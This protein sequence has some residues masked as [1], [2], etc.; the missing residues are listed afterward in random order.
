MQLRQQR[1]YI[2]NRTD[3]DSSRNALIQFDCMRRL[4][5]IESHWRTISHGRMRYYERNRSIVTV[6]DKPYLSFTD[7]LKETYVSQL[8][9][10]QFSIATILITMTLVALIIMFPGP[11][12]S[13][14]GAL[15]ASVV[16][17]L[18]T[19]GMVDAV[20]TTEQENRR[21]LVPYAV[22]LLVGL[23]SVIFFTKLFIVSVL[24]FF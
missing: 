1:T 13:L 11:C 6:C 10:D 9:S 3:I 15:T 19:S 12:A 7:R 24:K 17:S 4:R 23:A 14:F 8:R 16:C 2:K 18:I 20:R 21:L 22:V 5:S